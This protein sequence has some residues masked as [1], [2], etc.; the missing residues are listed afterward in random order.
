MKRRDALLSLSVAALVLLAVLTV[1]AIELSNTQA[2]SRQDVEARVHERGVLAGALIDS[3]FRTTQQQLPTY[4]KL[5]GGPVVSARTVEQK[6]AE[7]QSA[8]MAILGPTGTVLAHSRGFT[9]QARADLK[10]SAALAQVR[11]GHPYALGNVLPYGNSR[12]LDF[13]V[14]VPSPYGRRILLTGVRPF[15]LSGFLASELRE[16]PGVHGAH[17][18]VVDGGG[19]V[20]ASTNP[21]RPAGFQFSASGQVGALGQ[22]SGDRNGHY[23]VVTPLSNSTWRIVLAAPNGPL[24]ASVSGLRMWIPWLIFAAFA[25]VAV[26]ALALARRALR[27]TAEVRDANARLEQLNGKLASTNESLE[28][29]AAELA[30]SNSELDQFASIASHDLQEPLRKI[31]TFT[32]RVTEIEA[33]RLSDNGREYLERCNSAAERLQ[34]LIEDLLRFSRVATHGRPFA[35]VDLEQVTR[36][37][38]VDLEHQIERS[39]A[40]VH[41][42]RLETISADALQMRQLIQNLISNAIKFRRPGVAPEVWIDGSTD[43]PH[44]R[45]V[46]RDN[47]IGFDEQY[48]RRVFRVFERLHGRNEYPGTGIG[49]ALCRKIVERHGGTI[50]AASAPGVGSTFTVTLPMHQFEEVVVLAA[51]ADEP[52]RPAKAAHAA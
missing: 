27:A 41:V 26:L 22:T 16:I 36:G 38:L 14:A 4:E 43:G 31:R 25:A 11:T 49:L 50:R 18:Y 30:R 37:V 45:L 2:K 6:V 28:H 48:S 9:A 21:A 35:P 32:Q 46:V 47:G 15:S 40:T 34:R 24:F 5:Y 12:V 52:Q 33:D 44:E 13:A 3:L 23:Y 1:F 42:G 51:V 8:Y 39:G 7:G 17:N 10:L 19:T 20:L 29:R